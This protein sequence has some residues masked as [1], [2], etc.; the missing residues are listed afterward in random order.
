MPA[1]KSSKFKEYLPL[2]VV[3]G[4]ILIAVA[5]WQIV[6]G[7]FDGMES[8]RLFMAFFFLLFGFFKT[9]DWKA[10]I[11]MYAE[12]DIVAKRSRAYAA[13]YPVIEL[14]LGVFYLLN[15]YALQVNIITAIVMF[16]GSI[17][18]IKVLREKKKIHCACLGAVVKLPMT[19]VTV[20]ED[21]GMGVMALIMLATL[22]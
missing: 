12:Y 14:S 3:I 11:D 5:V 15:L 6:V 18:V 4:T 10:F 20:I 2:I 19:T 8:M 16:T 21:V 17:G 1:E 7:R 13:V 22:L 9:L